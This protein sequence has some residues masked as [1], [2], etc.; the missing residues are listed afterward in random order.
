MVQVDRGGAGGG[1]NPG[2]SGVS[3]EAKAI[4]ERVGPDPAYDGLAVAKGLLRG[5]RAGALATLDRAAGFPFA[6]LVTV[7]TDVDGA[8]LFL[9]SRLS[10]HTANLAADPRASVLLAERGRGDPLAHP[11]L[12]VIGRIAPADDPRARARFL[13]RHPK[14][15]LYAGFGDFAVFRMAVEGAHLNGGFARAMAVSRDDLL[16]RIDDAQSLL[17]LEESAVAH[18]NADH[19]EALALYATRLAGA[20]DGDWRAT[21]IDPDGIDLAAGDLTARVPFPERVSEGGRLRRV[22]KEMADAAREA[23]G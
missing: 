11:R 22:L 21:G 14:A 18:M 19:R 16:T 7:A 17:A 23:E 6:T 20:A 12:T 15:K 1:A 4:L 9:L 13:A 8:P 3:E 5:V 10:G 2:E